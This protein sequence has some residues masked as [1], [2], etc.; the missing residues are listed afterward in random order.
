MVR[1]ASFASTL[2][3]VLLHTAT[4]LEVNFD[5]QGDVFDAAST[6]AFGLMRS[7]TGNYTGDVPGNLPDPYFW[8]EAGAM[9][10]HL[11]DYWHITGDESYVNQ[12]V[13]AIVHQSGDLRDLMP[14]NQTHTEGNDDQG[15]W[16][17]S[18][19]AAAENN[20]PNPR[21][22]AAIRPSCPSRL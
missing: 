12:T 22:P 10:G 9:F 7:Y 13:Q 6:I 14:K 2:A 8:W 11:V 20:F 15:F 18:V 16:A 5:N 3:G 19:M 4:A 17:M 21:R 1:I